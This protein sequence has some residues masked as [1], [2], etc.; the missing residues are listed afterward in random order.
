MKLRKTVILVAIGL[1]ISVALAV[2]QE[3]RLVIVTNDANY[4]LAQFWINF[5]KAESVPLIRIKASEMDKYKKEKYLAILGGPNETEGIGD[6]VNQ[7]L[8]K[9]EVNF[10]SQ[11]GNSK[12]YLKS[13]VWAEGQRVIIFA[14][15]TKA[16]V[17]R[18][19]RNSLEKWMESLND[20]FNDVFFSIPCC[21]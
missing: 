16:D 17:E 9:E 4:E 11:P 7:L 8:T 19:R 13:D 18:A 5:L 21:N 2:A 10:V 6:I 1:V 12:M 15:A 3:H 20:W 14:G